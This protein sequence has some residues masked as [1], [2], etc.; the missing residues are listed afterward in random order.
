MEL[1]REQFAFSGGTVDESGPY[2]VIRGVLICGLTSEHG[3]DYLPGAWTDE[4]LKQYDGVASYA[5]HDRNGE[6]RDVNDKV[7]WFENPRR[8]PDGRPEGDYCLNPE[9]PL[10]KSV[11]WAAKHKPDFYAMSHR[12]HVAYGTRNGRKVVESFGRIHSVDLVGKGGTTGGIFEHGKG[13]GPVPQTVKEYL[14]KLAPRM[15]VDQ[16]IVARTLVREDDYAGA[17]MAAGAPDP[18]APETDAA[19]GLKSALMSALA[20]LL[21]EAFESGDANKVVSALKDFIK[22]HAKHTGKGPPDPDPEPDAA[23]KEAAAAAKK[24]A[25]PD[26]WELIRECQAEGFSPSPVQLTALKGLADPKDR[27]AF[28]REQKGLAAATKP[29]AAPRQAGG[30]KDGTVKEGADGDP[31]PPTGVELA[32]RRMAELSAEQRGAPPPK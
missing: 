12:A 32:R 11:V 6:P 25:G 7:G 29:K 21:D 26:P 31:D 9:H 1:V 2:P 23:A 13:G 15:G 30:G 3:Y 27:T 16:L 19:E 20:P 14:D 5:N 17:P 18:A 28:V 4:A 10:C 8:R 24:P 22:L